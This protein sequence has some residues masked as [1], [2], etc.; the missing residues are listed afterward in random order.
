M[1]SRCQMP[2]INREEHRVVTLTY[3]KE[4][5]VLTIEDEDG[6][7]KLIYEVNGLSAIY[8]GKQK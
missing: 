3:D 6:E 8:K 2:L 4:T 7:D 1:I 5:K